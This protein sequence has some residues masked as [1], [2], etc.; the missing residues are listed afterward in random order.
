MEKLES[1]FRVKKFVQEN[2]GEVQVMQT[3]IYGAF[4]AYFSEMCT[5]WGYNMALL[6]KFEEIS[7]TGSHTGSYHQLLCPGESR[8][9]WPGALFSSLHHVYF[10][11]GA[12]IAEAPSCGPEDTGDECIWPRH[13]WVKNLRQWPEESQNKR[14]RKGGGEFG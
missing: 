4:R 8:A 2:H 9:D 10:D 13:S 14:S 5:A 3:G 6:G 12:I 11:Q 1:S 7:L